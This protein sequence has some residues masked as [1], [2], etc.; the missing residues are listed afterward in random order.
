MEKRI[1]DAS[2]KFNVNFTIALDNPRGKDL[3]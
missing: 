2:H 1:R 3:Y